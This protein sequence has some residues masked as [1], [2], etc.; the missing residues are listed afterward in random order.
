MM[1][2]IIRVPWIIIRLELDSNC[3]YK[4]KETFPEKEK[5]GDGTGPRML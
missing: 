2:L 3:K 5:V 4:A 1:V